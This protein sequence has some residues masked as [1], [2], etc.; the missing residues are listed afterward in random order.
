M[1]WKTRSGRRTTAAL[2]TLALIGV[3]MPALAPPA[4]AA[5]QD[6]YASV[7]LTKSYDGTGHGTD[8]QTFITSANGFAPADDTPDDGVLAS[9]DDV[10]YQLQLQFGPAAARDAVVDLE[11][12]EWL[13]LAPGSF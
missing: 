7:S 1:Y 3:G 9:G 2:T 10:A 11:L 6:P 13:S 8:A 4:A 5:P 12:P